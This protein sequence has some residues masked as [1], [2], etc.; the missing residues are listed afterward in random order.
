MYTE[1]CTCCIHLISTSGFHGER[2]SLP[3]VLLLN[4]TVRGTVVAVYG[5]LS[6]QFA[7]QVAVG[8]LSR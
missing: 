1:L 2:V 3:L 7:L 4:Y 8:F 5:F 6:W